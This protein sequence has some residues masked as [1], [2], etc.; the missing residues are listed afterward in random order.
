MKYKLTKGE[1]CKFN[2]HSRIDLL[3]YK[4]TF[5][6]KKNFDNWHEFRLYAIFDFYVEVLFNLEKEDILKAEPITSSKWLDI[7]LDEIDLN[8]LLS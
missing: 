3:M 8:V 1:Y 4:G 7:Y 2:L 5:L 6:K